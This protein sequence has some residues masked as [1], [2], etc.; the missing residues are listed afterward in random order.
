MHAARYIEDQK[1]KRSMAHWLGCVIS[2]GDFSEGV[3]RYFSPVN[4]QYSFLDGWSYLLERWTQRFF[5]LTRPLNLLTNDLK[6]NT[7]L[8]RL[9]CHRAVLQKLSHCSVMLNIIIYVHDKYM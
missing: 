3:V 1:K 4:V 9:A 5:F 7:L 2:T 8:S 6:L